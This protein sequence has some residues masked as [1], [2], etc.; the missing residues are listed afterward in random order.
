MLGAVSLSPL[1]AAAF[2]YF[3]T[4][5]TAFAQ[6]AGADES[7]MPNGSVTQRLA[8]TP[9]QENA[10][11]SAVGR[12]GLRHSTIDVPEAIGTPV[13]PSVELDALPD[14]AANDVGTPLLKYAMVEND[15]VLVDA[16]SMRVV[17][18]IHGN[19]RP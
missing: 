14:A 1:I 12:H 13:P 6:S 15:I 5:G 8:L 17:D 7:I 18:V 2:A 16:F 9:A 19:A 3:L 10:I 11:Y 4:G